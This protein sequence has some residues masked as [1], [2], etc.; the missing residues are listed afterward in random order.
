MKRCFK[1]HLTL[2]LG[3]PS[4]WYVLSLLLLSFGQTNTCIDLKRTS[5]WRVYA[6]RCGLM[7]PFRFFTRW[8]Q[9]LV[10]IYL[11][12]ATIS[13]TTTAWSN[14]SAVEAFGDFKRF[15]YRD[16][17]VTTAVNCFTSFFSG[18]V[19]FTYLGFMSHKQGVHISTVAT[20]GICLNSFR[21][22]EVSCWFQVQVWC[23]RCIP[24]LL[25]LFQVRIFGPFCFSSCLSC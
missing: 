25:P 7:L 24:K 4:N 6:S 22:Q 17:L 2:F 13:F 16:C 23:F 20:E 1:S 14:S 9:D 8:V 18:F 15:C 12:P 11:M 21:C 3:I 19:I 5:A 10:C